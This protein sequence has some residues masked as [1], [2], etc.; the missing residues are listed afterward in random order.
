[1]LHNGAGNPSLATI[2]PSLQEHPI[3]SYQ[4]QGSQWISLVPGQAT[5]AHHVRSCFSRCSATA[6]LYHFLSK[7]L[8]RFAVLWHNTIQRGSVKPAKQLGLG[9]PCNIIR[10]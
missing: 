3:D 1:M 7:S 5:Y 8:K 10:P 2:Y 4:G 6:R 9:L